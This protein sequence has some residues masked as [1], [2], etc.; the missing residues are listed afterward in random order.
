[1]SQEMDLILRKSLDE[2]D[3][4]RTR[5]LVGLLVVMALFLALGFG[6]VLTLHKNHPEPDFWRMLIAN[7]ELMTFNVA[8]GVL[9]ICLFMT[10]MTRKI[11]KAIELSSKQ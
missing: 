8:F 9:G 6:I 11:L 4:L 2:L 3:R 10:R 5:Q 7:A 1:M